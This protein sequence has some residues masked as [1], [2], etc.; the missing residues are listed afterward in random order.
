MW[1]GAVATTV[2]RG[3]DERLSL[4]GEEGEVTVNDEER[5]RLVVS[6][7]KIEVVDVGKED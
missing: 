2:A 6:R 3:G 4:Y 7:K 1:R 5:K